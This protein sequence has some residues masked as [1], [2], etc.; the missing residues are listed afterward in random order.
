MRVLPENLLHNPPFQDPIRKVNA[1]LSGQAWLVL[2]ENVVKD[3]DIVVDLG[4]ADQTQCEMGAAGEEIVGEVQAF[5]V[6]GLAGPRGFLPHIPHHFG[7]MTALLFAEFLDRQIEQIT[8][9]K[10]HE[11]SH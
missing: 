8:E 5:Q 10:K 4:D 1:H 2:R 6:E 9:G 7:Q 11:I 3:P